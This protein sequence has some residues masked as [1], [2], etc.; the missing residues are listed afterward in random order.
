VGCEMWKSLRCEME[1]RCVLLVDEDEDM[2][3]VTEQKD[4]RY[5]VS[6]RCIGFNLV[7]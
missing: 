4:W 5:L 1:S 2:S 3:H 7:D 6:L